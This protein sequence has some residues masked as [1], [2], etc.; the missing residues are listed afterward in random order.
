MPDAWLNFGIILLVQFVLFVV[1]AM[2]KRK[3]ANI[4]RILVHG[5]VI[6]V[7]LGLLYDLLFGKYLGFF[8]YT[9]EFEMPFLLTNAAL[10]YGLFVASVLLLQKAP[11]L[12]FVAWISVVIIVYE[13]ANYIFPLWTYEFALPPLPFSVVLIAGYSSGA[14]LASFIAYLVF[15]YPFILLLKQARE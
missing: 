3:F 8:S 13:T 7:G 11:T 6:G 2:Y 4:P 1:C 10:S 9:P 5:I 12:H 15:K 14:L